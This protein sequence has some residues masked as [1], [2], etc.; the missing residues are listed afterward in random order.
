[1]TN[2]CPKCHYDN[3]G[4]ALSCEECGI[5]LDM[6]DNIPVVHT[7][8]M[9]S[10]KVELTTGST[11][12]GRYQIIEELG[13]G[14]MGKVYKANDTDI[15]E[16]VAIKLIRPEISTDKKTI[17]RFQNELKFARKIRHKNVC[18][19]YDLNKEEGNYYITMEFVDGED[20]K[21]FIRRS[22]QLN[23]GKTIAIAK[24]ICAGLSEAHGMGIVH[25]DLKPSNIM[26]DKDGNARIMDFGIARSLKGKGITGAGM[27]IGTPEYMSPEQVDGKETDQRSDIYSLGIILYKMLT[28]RLPYEGETPLSIAVQHKSGTPKNPQVYNAQIPDDLAKTILKCME[29]EKSDR[30]QNAEDLSDALDNIEQG[31]PSSE[32]VI[33]KQLPKTSKEITISLST[34]RLYLPILFVIAIAIIGLFLWRPW[35]PK[36]EPSASVVKPSIAVLPFKDLSPQ[37]DQQHLCSGIPSDLAQRLRQVEGLWIPAWASSSA[38]GAENIDLNEVGSKLNVE[39]VL[40]GTLQKADAKLRITVELINIVDNDVIWTDKYERD[41][42]GIFEL[43]DEVTVAIIDKLKVKLLGEERAGLSKRYTDNVEAYNQYLLGRHFWNK[44]T[45]NDM[46]RSIEYFKQAIEID[47]EYAL[48]YSGIADAYITLGAWGYLPEKEA[49]LKARG[50]AQRAI[51]IDSKLAEAYSSLGAVEFEYE[52]DWSSAEKYFRHAIELNPKYPT[53]HQWYSEFL[54]SMGRFDEAFIETQ[55]AQELDPLAPIIYVSRALV[56]Y[57][58]RKYDQALEFCLEA[59]E[60]DPNYSGAHFWSS[61]IYAQMQQYDKFLFE[62]KKFLTLVGADSAQIEMLDKIYEIYNTS[63]T[64]DAARFAI[65]LYQKASEFADIP[66]DSF[67]LPYS[68]LKDKEQMMIMLEKCYQE[69]LQPIVVL[70]VDPRLDFIRS[71]PRFQALLKKVGLDN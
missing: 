53:A 61:I 48:A 52:W 2:K 5:Q 56:L 60:L 34:K 19:M 51:E 69:R 50:Q 57:Y 1:M 16:K 27:I 21:S 18:Q 29:K 35:A 28:G 68:V 4:T 54:A 49:Y 14:G 64:E 11:F 33:P 41:E 8:T 20:L 63:G 39:T 10:P 25:R 46:L 24:Q 65:S 26:I 15:K 22:G 40:T 30:Y 37:M 58:A 23:V 32:H 44:R 42:G 70:K 43:Q 36:E 38:F 12:A 13:K 71:D 47:P 17:E 9:E 59:L 62:Q 67:L 55:K 66:I 31:I 6:I 3:L 7:E 45:E